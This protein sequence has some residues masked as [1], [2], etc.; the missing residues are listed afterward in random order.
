MSSLVNEVCLLSHCSK[1]PVVTVCVYVCVCVVKGHKYII[2]THTAR[3]Y[4]ENVKRVYKMYEPMGGNSMHRKLANI[5][6]HD[7]QIAHE[8]ATT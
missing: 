2:A 5:T 8:E 7:I 4:W 1:I 3:S 6:E